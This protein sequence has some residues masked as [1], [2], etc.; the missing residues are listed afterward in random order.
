MEFFN[1]IANPIRFRESTASPNYSD[2]W[3]NPYN[4]DQHTEWQKGVK[5][6]K[7]F[8]DS[9]LN[10]EIKVQFRYTDITDGN[11]KIYKWSESTGA[12]LVYGVMSAIEVSPSGWV[13]LNVYNYSFTPQEV[14]TYYFDFE[15]A[16]YISDK[17]VV[18]NSEKFLNKMFQL[19]YYNYENDYGLVYYKDG[20][21]VFEGEVYYTGNF[22]K[23][24]PKNEISGVGTDRGN[25]R[26][27]RSTP[28]PTYTL[29]IDMVT[30]PDVE[31]FNEIFS[32]S[33][34][35]V[36]GITCQNEEGI[37]SDKIKG[38]NLYKITVALDETDF[39][40]GTK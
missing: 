38:S 30:E 26:K 11:I 36:N 37:A 21:K 10:M 35:M 2:R 17:F 24:S 32:N 39:N 8:R 33:A 13:G 12:Y 6:A 5:P 14:G 15:E 22:I 9:V 28:I 7:V 31:M 1:P 19:K 3:P 16:E 4:I 23:G 18:H 34:L 27:T 20:V 29:T 40:Y 25:Y